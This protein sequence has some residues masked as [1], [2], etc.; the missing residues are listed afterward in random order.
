MKKKIWKYCG[1]EFSSKSDRLYL[2][3]SE[4]FEDEQLVIDNHSL[5]DQV[6][7]CLRLS[8]SL[9]DLFADGSPGKLSLYTT[10]VGTDA[11]I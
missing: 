1:T 2:S 3:I 4:L 5:V 7:H 10:G 9:L 11:I 8:L 6:M